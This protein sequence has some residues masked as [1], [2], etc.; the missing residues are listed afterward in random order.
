M[1]SPNLKNDH[2]L[3]LNTIKKY[4]NDANLTSGENKLK[5]VIALF[6]Y[7]GTTYY[8][9]YQHENF[10]KIVQDKFDEELRPRLSQDE[11]QKYTLSLFNSNSRF[12]DK[13]LLVNNNKVECQILLTDHIAISWKDNQLCFNAHHMD[14]IKDIA[15][16]DD[17]LSLMIH[18]IGP[19]TYKSDSNPDASG[20]NTYFGSLEC[21]IR[22]ENISDILN[23]ANDYTH[24]ND[25]EIYLELVLTKDEYDILQTVLCSWGFSKPNQ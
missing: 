16:D 13:H 17:S 20:L 9:W 21:D 18:Y 12:N 2:D 22:P 19:A 1:E 14:Y 24:I 10:A 5:I 3:W 23:S 7:L 25:I 4:L 11:I 15:Y 6:D 8:N